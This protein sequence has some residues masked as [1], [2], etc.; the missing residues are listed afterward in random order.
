MN[1]NLDGHTYIQKLEV[2]YPEIDLMV[3]SSNSAKSHSYKKVIGCWNRVSNHS[4]NTNQCW[5]EHE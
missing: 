3:L 1:V 5:H 4:E 2:S